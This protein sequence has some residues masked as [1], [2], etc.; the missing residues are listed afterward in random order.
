MEIMMLD[1]AN[2]ANYNDGIRER[3]V[4]DAVISVFPH[5]SLSYTRIRCLRAAM[6][7]HKCEVGL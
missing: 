3:L 7:H 4:N 6:A 1:L 2:T 5:V